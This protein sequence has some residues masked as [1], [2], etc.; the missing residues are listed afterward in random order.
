MAYIKT[1]D[2]NEL[3]RVIGILAMD[4]N[5]VIGYDNDLIFHN[6]DDLKQFKERTE[7][8]ICIM[9]RKTFESIGKILPNR[10]TVIV[11]N[12]GSDYLTHIVKDLKCPN[13]TP[14]PLVISSKKLAYTIGSIVQSLGN[15]TVYVCGGSSIYELL[16]PFV[17]GYVVTKYRVDVQKDGVKL[18]LLP[19]DYDP[20]KLVRISRSMIGDVWYNMITG[21]FNGIPYAIRYYT[22]KGKSWR[23]YP[24]EMYI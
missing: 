23:A 20:D 9:G 16:S 14:I 13:N 18:G 21:D 15:K 17:Y 24:D 10:Q 8:Q 5:G 6:K 4:S 22:I 2:T 3:V 11:T 1:P 12:R 7:N 19:A